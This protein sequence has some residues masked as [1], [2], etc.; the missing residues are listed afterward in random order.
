MDLIFYVL[1]IKVSE[2]AA[3]KFIMSLL[4]HLMYLLIQIY[5]QP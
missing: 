4:T 5:E 3:T 1:D 2:T